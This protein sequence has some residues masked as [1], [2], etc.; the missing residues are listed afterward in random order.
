MGKHDPLHDIFFS[1]SNEHCLNTN[2]K[3]SDG[4]RNKSTDLWS[5]WLSNT[6]MEVDENTAKSLTVSG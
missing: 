1:T 6:R 4:A 3:G 2:I 5:F